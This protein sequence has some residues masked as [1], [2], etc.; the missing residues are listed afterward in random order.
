MGSHTRL[1][2]LDL[3]SGIGGFSLGLERSGYFETVAFCEIEK[4]PRALLAARWPGVPVYDDVAKL[5]AERLRS[6]GIVVDA[7]CGGFPCQ[8]VSNAGAPWGLCGGLDG[9]RSGLWFQYARLIGELRPGIVFVENVAGLLGRGIDRVLGGLAALGYDAEWHCIPAG[10][11]GLPHERDRTWIAAYPCGSR[12]SRLKE[13]R[14]VLKSTLAEIAKSG[15]EIPIARSVVD[16]DSIDLCGGDGL[17]FG[18]ARASLK[19]YGNAVVPLIPE[20]L[21]RAFGPEV[22]RKQ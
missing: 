2:L 16:D 7:I 8:D 22:E 1:C 19:L 3:F 5:T 11:L 20:A 6:D 9:A 4:M 15:D 14:G 13:R 18:L 12:L 21:G 10:Y 17:S